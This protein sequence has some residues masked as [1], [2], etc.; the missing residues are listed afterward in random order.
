MRGL[1]WPVT[2]GIRSIGPRPTCHAPH[3]D[4]LPEGE[5]GR[6]AQESPVTPFPTRAREISCNGEAPAAS[7]S[8]HVGSPD[9]GLSRMDGRPPLLWFSIALCVLSG[10]SK[11][12]P[13]ASKVGPSTTG[14]SRSHPPIPELRFV[15][16][17]LPFRYDRGESGLALPPETTGGG[18]GLIDFDGDGDLDLFFAQGVPLPVGKA[19]NPP[20]DVLLENLGGRKF[21]D[22]SSRVGL[23]SKGY[24][25]GVTVADYDGDGDPDVYVTR[26]G[27]STLWRNDRGRFLDATAEAGVA[28]G[29]WSLGAAFLDFDEDGDLDLFVANYFGFNP[30]EAPFLRD[31]ATG[32][33]DYGPPRQFLGQPDVLHRNEGGGRFV[34]VTSAAGVA[35]QGRGMGV[36]ASDLDGDG[37][38]DLL[39][40]NDA[41]ENAL[42]RNKGDG[43]FEDV[44]SLLGLALNG[45]GQAE[46][47]M[48][49]AL[50]DTDGDGLLEPFITHFYGE[51]DTLWR[52][53]RSLD[54]HL[55]YSDETLQA[56]L[57]A[58]GRLL[59]GWGTAFADFDLDG[60]L[61]LVVACGHIRREP[62]QPYPYEN[63]PN[64]WKNDG[65]G[66][67][68][69]AVAAAGPYFQSKHMAR[70]LAAGDLDADGDLDL[71]VV[72]HHEPSVVL[73]NESPRKGNWLIVDLKG[74]PPNT[75]AIGARL[76][77]TVG[78]RRLVRT[79]D[80]GGS[81]LSSSDRRAHLG[82]GPL[83]RVEKLEVR[84]PSGRVESKVDLPSGGV[85]RWVEGEGTSPR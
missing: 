50:G 35:G 28:G 48:G 83:D 78:G 27:S 59:T 38:V 41:E 68:V 53:V 49:I 57:A 66:R 60:H 3:P 14:R 32:K 71:V 4:P 24:G 11:A 51:H 17:D 61:D 45:E 10:C 39:V 9:W 77:A 33:A 36:I 79:V 85:I 16:Q 2:P 76:V 55:S 74:K 67:F 70:G 8:H 63:P 20:S 42:W 58:A 12:G 44:A 22:I 37:R 23:T 56:G 30:L 40:A 65:R 18:V 80:G 72:H 69:H 13:D 29:L 73:W 19:A 31:P 6:E 21:E 46:A 47:N 15:A 81:Y 5:G 1:A 62:G 64:L 34:D 26:Y 7:S 84:W 75:D 82:L 52:P 54:G 25:Q 43:T